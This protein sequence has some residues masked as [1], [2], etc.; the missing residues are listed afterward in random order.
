MGHMK[1]QCRAPR[2][3]QHNGWTPVPEGQPRDKKAVTFGMV[4][5][6]ENPDLP[7]EVREGLREAKAL[8]QAAIIQQRA[9]TTGPMVT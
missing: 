5:K 4:R 7:P 8:S 2:K 6:R 9:I 3:Q 1:S